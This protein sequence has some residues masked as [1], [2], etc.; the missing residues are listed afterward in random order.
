MHQLHPRHRMQRKTPQVNRN[1]GIPCAMVLRPILVLSSVLRLVG[2]RHLAKA[3]C[4]SENRHPHSRA[5][6][7][8]R[9]IGT[10]RL[11][12]PPECFRRRASALDIPSVHCLPL[13]TSV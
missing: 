7:Q 13:P 9:E 4:P 2:H 8:R 5:W 1:I 11:S 6:S 3:A 12:R 10:T